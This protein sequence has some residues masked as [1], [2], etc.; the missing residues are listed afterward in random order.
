MIGRSVPVAAK[1]STVRIRSEAPTPQ[2][3]PKA[4]GG[5]GSASTCRTK[6]S[7][8]TPI[9]VRPAVSKLMVPHHGMPTFAKASAAAANSSGAEMVSTQSTSAPPSL[10]PAA[11]SSNISTAVSWLS[12]PTVPMISPVGPTEPATTTLR[13]AASATSRP[14]AAAR[15]DSSKAREAASCSLSR[16]AL[17]PKELVRKMSEP[18]STA[19]R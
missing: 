12:V 14:S 7:E 11:V 17:A 5:L 13:P 2:L 18:A 9:M 4:S 10:S 19:L 3:A 15:R 6:S 1:P 8:V 16:E